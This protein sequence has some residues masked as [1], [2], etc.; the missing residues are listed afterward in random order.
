MSRPAI[1]RHLRVL[2][3]AGLVVSRAEGRRQWYSLDGVSL[4]EVDTWIGEVH[5]MWANAM[6]SLK[7][8]VEEATDADSE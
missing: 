8:F 5:E 1:S 4:E 2:R 3:E 7:K 6:A